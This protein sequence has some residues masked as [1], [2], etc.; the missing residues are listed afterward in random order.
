VPGPQFVSAVDPGG[1]DPRALP[2]HPWLDAGVPFGFSHETCTHCPARA[3]GAGSSR[4]SASA[5]PSVSAPRATMD[6]VGVLT[7]AP[8]LE[9]FTFSGTVPL[10]PF[11]CT[12]FS[13][14]PPVE[15]LT[16]NCD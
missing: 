11:E 13:R 5:I 10:A 2:V 16:S 6:R 12:W 1:G 15:R 8:G 4:P 3:A 9:P 14:L 7:G